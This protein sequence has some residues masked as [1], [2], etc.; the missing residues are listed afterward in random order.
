VAADVSDFNEA[1]QDAIG[2]MLNSTLVYVDG[3]P[4][5]GRAAVTGHISIP[6]GSNAAVL[7]SFTKAQLDAAVSDANLQAEDATLT[8]LAAF[9][10]NGLVVQTAADTFAGRS[11]AGTSGKI[12]L[13]NGDGVSGNPTVNVGADIVDETIANTYTAGAKQSFTHDATTAGLRIVPASGDPSSPADG[14]IWYN[15]TTGLFKKR[16]NGTTSDLDTT[17]GGGV[18]DGDKG[19]VIVSGSGTTWK[20]DITGLTAAAP[21]I[22]DELPVSDVS[23]SNN[24]KATL[25]DLFRAMWRKAHNYG[26]RFF[27]DF[28]N[29]TTAT[30]NDLMSETNSGTSAA[31]A[32]QV[33]DATNHPG[34]LRSTT[35][36]TA[37]GRAALASG[38]NIFRLGGGELVF[39]TLVNV[40]TLSTST[41][42]FQLVV[43][44]L[45]TLTA[46]NQ[47]DA[48]AFVYDEGGVSTGSTASGNWQAVTSNGAARSWNAGASGSSTVAAA[49]WVRLKI[50]I[51]AA[52]TQADFYVNDT[53]RYSH[54]TN[55]PSGSNAVGFGWLLI[56]SVGT[57]ARTMD[58]DYVMVEQDF[59]T[60][61]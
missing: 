1:A 6:A 30:A 28:I 43:G 23:D 51:N 25:E 4:E 45:D 2:A 52:G 32:N 9:N 19:E 21:D 61:R 60:A 42:R 3:T 53:L 18:S 58:A 17:G 20:L 39:E 34:L 8:A 44:L 31:T 11:I 47:T 54:T 13:T 24:K 49:T 59:T 46:A 10:T 14:D 29:E 16:Q 7:G 50:I 12:V 35:G 41:E 56:K 22:L 27:T 38:T 48:V 55:I 57:T 37:T 33:S 26:F 36:T 15:S 40:T 5:L